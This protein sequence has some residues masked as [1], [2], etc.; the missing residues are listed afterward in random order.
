MH[1][2]PLLRGVYV[3]AYAN[4]YPV[5]IANLIHN[6]TQTLENKRMKK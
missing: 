1:F 2:D 6:D 4:M 3:I 5:S